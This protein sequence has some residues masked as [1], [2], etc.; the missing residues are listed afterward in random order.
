[1]GPRAVPSQARVWAARGLAVV[2][3]G[4]QIFGFPAFGEGAA[5]PLNDALDLVAG[6]A[7]V[8]L[9]GWH[10]AFLPTFLTELVP[11]VD[12]FPT[13]TAA[14]VFVTRGRRWLP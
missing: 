3:D 8:L 9:L 13:W 7:F 11:V 2:V 5:S 1:M 6:A 4:I 12:V 14:V 10:I